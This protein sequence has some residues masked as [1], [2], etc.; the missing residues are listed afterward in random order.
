MIKITPSIFVSQMALEKEYFCPK[1]LRESSLLLTRNRPF[2][3][4]LWKF[5]RATENAL[6]S[7]AASFPLFQLE[8]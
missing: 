6:S 1:W 5:D 7:S 8:L 2:L 4:W 3:S